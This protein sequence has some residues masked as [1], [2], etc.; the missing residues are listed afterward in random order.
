M[1]NRLKRRKICI[2]FPILFRYVF[3]PVFLFFSCLVAPCAASESSVLPQQITAAVLEDFPPLYTLDPK[4]NPAGFAIDILDHVGTELDIQVDY[5]VM[6]NWSDAMQA[7]REG[8]A[9]LIPGIGISRERK[10]EFLF[11][12]IIETIPVSCFVRVKNY[13][14]EGVGSLAGHRV[15]VI[16]ESA[17]ASLLRK[18]EKIELVPF[19]NIDT[20]L[21]QLLAGDVDAFVFPEPVLLK[22]AREAGVDDKIKVVGQPLM[23][24]KRAFLIRKGD[25]ELVKLFNPVI[26]D[27]TQ[28]DKYRKTYLKWYGTPE[29]F[30]TAQRVVW[31]MG[32]IIAAIL[33]GGAVWW[34]IVKAVQNRKLQAIIEEKEQAEDALK[35]SETL[36][37]KYFELGLVGMAIIS[38]DKKWLHVNNRLCEILGY[39]REELLEKTWAEVTHPDD[40]GADV[41]QYNRMLAGEIDNYSLDKRFRRKNGTIVFTTSFV[42]CI[43]K[44]DG[45]VDYV[46][47]HIQDITVRKRFEEELRQAQ[48]MEAIGTLAGG[49][50]HDFNNVLSPIIG[51]SELCM[52]EVEE[53]SRIYT[54]LEEVLKAAGRAKE[55]VKQILTFSRQREEEK[56]PLYIQ[57]IIKEA[58]KLL[59]ASLPSTIEIRQNIDTTSGYILS[60]PTQVHQVMMNL[61]T[62]AYHAMSE[63]GG[64]LEVAVKEVEITPEEANP[65]LQLKPGK[66]YV[67]LIVKDTG[68]GMPADVKE[69]IFE[70]YFT[71]KELGK[72]TGMGLAVVHGIVKSC[73]GDVTVFSEPGKGA[74]FHVYWPLYEKDQSE[75][76]FI[77][78]TNAPV[79][80]GNEHIL[81]VDDEEQVINMLHTMLERLGYTVTYTTSSLQALKIFHED[82]QKFDVV[83][84]DQTMPEMT[85]AELALGLMGIR[86]NIPIILCTGFSEVISR[87]E[88]KELG[89][90]EY[91]MKPVVTRDLAVAIRNALGKST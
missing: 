43:R 75:D 81:L 53:G 30:W 25:K 42:T 6:E 90:R 8:K 14:M 85:G 66:R 22:K 35:K 36:F 82:P 17:A 23:E 27:F 9:D 89:I 60:D 24:L 15:A 64:I 54:N 7:V 59:R 79:P 91:V 49:I 56:Q 18:R 32:I 74:T 5:V 34:H 2:F 47:C 48:K 20:A 71:T 40:L 61:C 68:P 29:P 65:K 58:L 3:L 77:T 16:G 39:T 76:D 41:T 78:T 50:A 80:T 12:E 26:R 67:R 1:V 19:P 44:D 69:R 10:A 57:P 63:R 51:Y 84:T 31:F 70:P 13:E 72:G 37:R 86:E 52:N 11:S 88:A 87:E 4:G 73:G 38:V 83:I 28:S 55:L 33:V 46:I 21:L 62:N 45:E